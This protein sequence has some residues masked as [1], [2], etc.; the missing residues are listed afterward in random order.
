MREIFLNLMKPFVV[1]AES[2]IYK[3]Q[4]LDHSVLSS[5]LFIADQFLDQ[6]LLIHWKVSFSIPPQWLETWRAVKGESQLISVTKASKPV[7]KL[8]TANNKD[9]VLW[10]IISSADSCVRSVL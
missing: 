6:N 2:I 3:Y 10:Q 4:P 9:F 1:F 7:F 5:N 8:E